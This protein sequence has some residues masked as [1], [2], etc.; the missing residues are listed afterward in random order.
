LLLL[1]YFYPASAQYSKDTAEHPR[2]I[3][4]V[5]IGGA[6]TYTLAM[7]GL[8]QVW[9]KPYPHTPFHFFNDDD[10][11][12]QMDKI[13]HGYTA[14]MDGYFGYHLMRW[15]GLPEKKAIW[16]GGNWGLL[17]QTTIEVFDAFSAEWGFSP[18]DM[19]ANITGTA[20]FVGQQLIWHDQI[21]QPR[22]SFSPTPYAKMNK[23]LLGNNIAQQL[24]KD[25][26]G[27]TY[28][29]SMGLFRFA[30][31]SRI[32]HWLNLAVGIGAD[33]MLRGTYQDQLHDPRFS[34][35][36]RQRQIFFSPDLDLTKIH[37]H[38]KFIKTL[39]ILFSPMK[40]PA[41]AIEV[42]TNGK[43]HF[44]WLYF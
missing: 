18:G 36:P 26:N 25:Y 6:A 33:G 13:G 5:G 20:L 34:S 44:Y 8:Y 40:M 17:L 4:A 16:Y 2:R 21:L 39:F 19:T 9:Y 29:L 27:Q 41:P 43:W 35:V 22:F 15:T 24:I 31:Q 42:N 38:N 7:T 14:W 3:A 30:P 28:W 10:E 37:T 11:W 32:P 1:I 12:M 23:N